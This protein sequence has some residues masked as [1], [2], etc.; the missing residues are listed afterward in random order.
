MQARRLG[1]I[2]AVS[3]N[4]G[5]MVGVGPFIT[6]PLLMR[7][8][9]G[10]EALVAWVLGAL[11]G[12]ADGLAWSELAAAFPGA[13]GTFHFYDAIGGRRPWARLLKFLFVWQFLLSAPLELASGGIGLGYY[14]SFLI[15]ELKLNAWRLALPIPGS[16]ALVWEV[17]RSQL[18]AVGLTLLIVGM[19]Y[20]RI[21][22]AG[23]LMVVLFAGVLA[24]VVWMIVAGWTAFDPSLTFSGRRSTTAAITPGFAFALG[25]GLQIAMYD[26]FGYYQVCYLGDEVRAP[27][28]T[29][30][31]AIVISVV[32]ISGLYLLMNTGI[33]G[34]LPIAEV[35]RSEHIASDFMMKRYGPTA[36]YLVTGLILWAGATSLFA[37]MLGYSRVPYAAARSGHFFQTFAALHPS[38]GFP[39]RSLLALGAI[40]AF[41]C[42]FDLTTVIEALIAL[43][44]LIQFVGQ[45]G[46]VLWVRTQPE[47]ESRLRFRMPLFPIPA[48]FALVGW[49]FVYGTLNRTIIGFSLIT[50]GLGTMAYF[51]WD[52]GGPRGAADA[53]SGVGP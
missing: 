37:G 11:L 7:T 12:I 42:L 39:H 16:H 31:R 24:T 51:L 49:L 2:Q 10:P 19:A 43:R 21:E 40:T 36:A 45:I 1:L 44:I 35:M 14:A 28:R 17:T 38:G 27:E 33:L 26:L 4:M 53:G 32:G 41:A 52:R 8:M 22:A 30:P 13:G 47:L 5:M 9:G 15:P 46:A 18:V 3:L 50:L 48:L 6:I 34:V 25:A 20:R 23:K 29:L